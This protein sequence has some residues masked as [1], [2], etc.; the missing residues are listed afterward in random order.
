LGIAFYESSSSK[1]ANRI[2]CLARAGRKWYLSGTPQE[3][4]VVGF[5]SAT[6]MIPESGSNFIDWVAHPKFA[7]Q[8]G[9]FESGA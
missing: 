1:L 5:D 6:S 7:I 8:K 2:F 9:K 3:T 4:G